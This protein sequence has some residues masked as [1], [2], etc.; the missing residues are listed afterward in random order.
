MPALGG[1]PRCDEET[2]A[3]GWDHGDRVRL[4]MTLVLLRRKKAL[5]HT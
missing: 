1:M 4:G 5:L 2:A 3:A